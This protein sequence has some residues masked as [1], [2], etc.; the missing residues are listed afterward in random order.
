[1]HTKKY[2]TEQFEIDFEDAQ[3][4][5]QKLDILA[6]AKERFSEISESVKE[7]FAKCH[8]ELLDMKNDLVKEQ[9][10]ECNKDIENK[11]YI[12]YV[13]TKTM[14]DY[15]KGN[16]YY[17]RVDNLKDQYTE[18]GIGD[19]SKELLEYL[20]KIKPVVWIIRDAGIG[21]PKYKK[22][23]THELSEYFTEMIEYVEDLTARLNSVELRALKLVVTKYTNDA[24]LGAEIRKIYDEDFVK[25]TPNDED[26]GS[27]IRSKF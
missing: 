21:T 19:V 17:I 16:A 1:M 14:D 10:V 4:I 7:A 6:N 27:K 20:S 13:C 5:E 12:L 22:I 25:N 18:T 9:D 26:L 24:E 8:N 3:S 2:T 23:F 15:I 11:K